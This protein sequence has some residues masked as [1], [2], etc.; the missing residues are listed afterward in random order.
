MMQKQFA[1]YE[2]TDGTVHENIRVGLKDK[3]QCER[4]A[5]RNQWDAEHDGFLMS[6]F[7]AWHASKRIGIHTLGFEEWKDTVED[8]LVVNRDA[9][10]TDTPGDDMGLALS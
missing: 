2:T 6:A 1:S 8:V 10:G 4:T 3:L 5:K 7:L 9:E